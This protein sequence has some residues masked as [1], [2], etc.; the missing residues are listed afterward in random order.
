VSNEAQ[1]NAPIVNMAA[2]RKGISLALLL[3]AAPTIAAGYDLSTHPVATGAVGTTATSA[4]RSQNLRVQRITAPQHQQQQEVVAVHN[5]TTQAVAPQPQVVTAKKAS[6]VDMMAAE[7]KPAAMP[8]SGEAMVTELHQELDEVRQHRTNIAQLQQTLTA[9]VALLRESSAL[10]RASATQ[11][12]RTMAKLQVR[13]TEQLVKDLSSML[14]DSRA[15]AVEDAKMLLQQATEVRN[16][17]DT[18]A[19]EA[20][21]EIHMLSSKAAPAKGAGHHG[22]RHR[23][24][25]AAAASAVPD[26][27]AK[28]VA[29]AAMPPAVTV[30]PSAVE[31]VPPIV[32]AAAPHQTAATAEASK[33]VLPAVRTTANGT[34][35][36]KASSDSNAADADLDDDE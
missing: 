23:H 30:A 18:L 29:A 20:S 14:R 24:T 36:A 5:A 19:T 17:A 7:S 9:D 34:I 1:A 6:M 33:A 2:I 28:A 13:K 26:D 21:N 15:E 27:A 25:S 35:A 3:G 16:A 10:Q 4:K 8:P 11:Q 22:G 12:S 31:A 32:V